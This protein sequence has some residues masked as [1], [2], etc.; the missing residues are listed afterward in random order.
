MLCVADV[1]SVP[2]SHEGHTRARSQLRLKFIKVNIQLSV[3]EICFSQGCCQLHSFFRLVK[4]PICW[5][6]GRLLLNKHNPAAPWTRDTTW[7]L[8]TASVYFKRRHAG[9]ADTHLQWVVALL[10]LVLLICGSLTVT[11]ALW[12]ESGSSHRPLWWSSEWHGFATDEKTEPVQ[13]F[14]RLHHFCHVNTWSKQ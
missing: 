14:V 7:K 2:L 11:A 6:S 3:T 12:K 9:I 4:D 5:E 13:W 10:S 1:L 8:H